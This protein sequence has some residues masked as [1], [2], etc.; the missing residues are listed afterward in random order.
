MMHLLHFSSNKPFI[1]V[2]AFLGLIIFGFWVASLFP[3]LVLTL[4]VSM[5]VAFILKP[6]VHFL[7]FD[8]VSGEAL[9][10]VWFFYWSGV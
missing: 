8:L 2:L 9:P 5:L 6:L 7:E 4:V 3:D 10:S 1:K